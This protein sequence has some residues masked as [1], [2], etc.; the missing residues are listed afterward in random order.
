MFLA[1]GADIDYVT[2][3]EDGSPYLANESNYT[4][5]FSPIGEDVESYQY[6]GL[7]PF[8]NVTLNAA[9]IPGVAFRGWYKV[10][11][12]DRVLLTTNL[13]LKCRIGETDTLYADFS[14]Y[15]DDEK[16]LVG[17]K[18]FGDFADALAIANSMDDKVILQLSDYTIPAGN[19]TIPAGVTLLVPHSGAQEEPTTSI[20]RTDIEGNPSGAY[21]KLTLAEG[22]HLNV[23]G[24]IEVSG[25]QTVGAANTGA[26][27]GIG[28]PS[29]PTFGQMILNA[30]STITLNSGATFRAWGYVTGTGEIDARR[31]AIVR[32]QF[33]LMDWKGQSNTT[34]MFHSPNDVY[35]VLP[36][37][38]YYIQNIEAPTKYHPGSKLFA[39]AA[40]HIGLGIINMDNAGIIGVDYGNGT[41]DEA[42]F[43]M[44]NEDDSED[45]W[46]RKYYNPATDQQV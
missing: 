17:Y 31:G 40:V 7:Y 1:V 16:F 9:P 21:C 33:Q 8:D 24:T 44:N 3:Y 25:K 4:Y 38:Q 12:D 41:K 30:G 23:Y 14:S 35:K 27:V 6:E 36:V 34:S 18:T 28:R 46:V 13:Q 11:G 26:D 43:L 2:V 42:L 20:K 22:A 37:N 45:T 32:E 29:G 19:Y 39:A 10:E 5:D 15:T